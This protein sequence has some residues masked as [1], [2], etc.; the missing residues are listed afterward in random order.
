[1]RFLTI[2]E[3]LGRPECPYMRRW[4]I[5]FGLFSVRLHHWYSS[6]DH[7]AMHDHPAWFITL[8]LR[9]KYTDITTDGLEVMRPGMIRYRPALH[10]HTVDVHKDGCWTL[11]LFGPKQRHWG[12]WIKNNTKWVKSNKYFLEHGHHPCE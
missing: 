6:D 10:K 9:G 8:I 4:V 12:F 3:K 11:V 5:N 2:G 1:M 7:R